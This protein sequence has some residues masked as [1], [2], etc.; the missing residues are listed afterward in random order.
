MAVGVVLWL[1]AL[2]VL[3]IM[4]KNDPD[5]RKVYLRHLRYKRYY[6]AT[7]SAFKVWRTSA[8]TRLKDPWKR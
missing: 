5:L 2:F 1:F 7:P 3:R 8:D 6:A 4:A